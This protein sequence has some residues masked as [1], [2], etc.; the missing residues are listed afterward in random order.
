MFLLFLAYSFLTRGE[1][2]VSVPSESEIRGLQARGWLPDGLPTSAEGLAVAYDFD[3]NEVWSVFE[4]SID[5]VASLPAREA[6]TW[7]WPGDPGNV[8]P[9]LT[10]LRRS[11]PSTRLRDPSRAHCSRA[12]VE[13]F[14]RAPKPSARAAAEAGDLLAR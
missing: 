12:E 5:E 14:W 4:C 11:S 10:P 6:G 13:H 7:E 1:R 3:S 9:F 8:L 2:P